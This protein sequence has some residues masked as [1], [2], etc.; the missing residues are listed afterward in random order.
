MSE[1]D[2]L[3]DCTKN[4]APSELTFYEVQKICGFPSLLWSRTSRSTR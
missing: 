4:N 3:W 1:Y 2:T